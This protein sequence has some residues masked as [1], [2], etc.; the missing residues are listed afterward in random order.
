MK[1]LLA[2]LFLLSLLTVSCGKKHDGIELQLW[3]FGDL[4]ALIEWVRSRVDSFQAAHPGVRVVQSEKS[5]N[6]I[7]ELLYANLT[8]GTGPDIMNVHA[9]YAAEF[10]GAGFFTPINTFEDFEEVKSLFE[11]GLMESTRHGNNYYGLPCSGIAFTLV[12]NADLFDA[13]GI[14]PPRTWSQFR[15]AAR[16]LTKDTN[17]DGKTDQWGLVLLGADRGSFSYRFAPFLFKAGQDILTDD[18]T[19]V[20]FN[21]PLG[22]E[23]LRLFVDMHQVDHSITPGFLAY[24]HS[25]VNDLFC[26]NKVAMSIEGP[27]FRTIVDQKSPGKKFYTVPVPVPDHMIALY[28]SLPTLQDMMMYSISAFT[29]HPQESWELMKSMRTLEADMDWITKDLGGIATTTGAL[30]SPEAERKEDLALYRRELR[31]ARPWPPHPGIISIAN[32][33]ITPWVQ[34]AIVGELSPEEAMAGAAAEAQQILD[35]KK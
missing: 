28:D 30:Y 9:N 3:N 2:L 32:N 15:E 29:K 14:A 12:C 13:E 17:G 7:R 19:K 10:G 33:V 5:W 35:G 23:A 27:W 31:F 16:R 1:R 24:H 18:L 25:E 26:S 20:A 4:P 8:S 11:P 21:T 6:M 22:V 34:R